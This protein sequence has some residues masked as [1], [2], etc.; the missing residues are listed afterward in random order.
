MGKHMLICHVAI[1]VTIFIAALAVG[2]GLT[3][4]FLVAMVAG[5]AGMVLMAVTGA[6]H[7][8][9]QEGAQRIDETSPEERDQLR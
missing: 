9:H 4:S 6:G 8:G 5:C 1:P 7:R 2:A 3:T